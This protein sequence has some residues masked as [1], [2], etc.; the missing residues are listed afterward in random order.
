MDGIEESFDL[1]KGS[2]LRA[3]GYELRQG[4]GLRQSYELRHGSDTNLGLVLIIVL[5]AITHI[6]KNYRKTNF[7]LQML[8][9][10]IL[11]RK[12]KCSENNET[13]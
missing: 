9:Y 6:N 4:Y 1:I 3:T 11:K 2:V 5:A 12:L 13:T 7:I 10:C 8:I